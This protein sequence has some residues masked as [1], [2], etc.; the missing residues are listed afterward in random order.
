MKNDNSVRGN[1][2]FNLQ[3]N[4]L[5]LPVLYENKENC[6]GCSACYSICPVG[7]ITMEPDEEGFLYPNVNFKKC[8][9]CFSCIKVCAFKIDQIGRG[10]F[11]TNGTAGNE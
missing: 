9:K 3:E 1:K 2:Y 6:C 8:I 11:I 4:N 5:A 7:A 10:F